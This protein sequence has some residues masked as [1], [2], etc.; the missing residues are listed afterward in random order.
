[1]KKYDCGT[2][3]VWERIWARGLIVEC[4]LKV[5]LADCPL[6]EVRKLPL[7]ERIAIVNKMPIAELDT[8]L[9]QHKRCQI[10]RKV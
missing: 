2:E 5:P 7:E 1:M 8:L 3:G 10:E 9:E 6:R 4:P